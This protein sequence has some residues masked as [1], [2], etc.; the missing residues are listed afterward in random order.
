MSTDVFENTEVVLRDLL[1]DL[2]LGGRGIGRN[3]DLSGAGLTSLATVDL[4]LAIEDRFGIEFPERMLNR[5]TFATLA[6]LTAA[7]NSLQS[8]A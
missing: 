3:D 8:V 2:R 6:T 1:T 7:V 4:M 5:R